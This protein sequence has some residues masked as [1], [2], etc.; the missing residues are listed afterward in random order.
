MKD[1]LDLFSGTE[2]FY[3]IGY[4]FGSLLTL[5]IAKLLESKGKK[6]VVTIIDGSPQFIHKLS[7]QVVPVN[8]D[9]NIQS[10]ILLTCARLLF[11]DEFHEIAKNIFA[12]KTWET[13]LKS[14]AEVAQERSLYSVEYGSKMLT[15]LITRLKISLAADKILLSTLTNTPVSLIRPAESSAKDL[16]EDY[17]LGKY[18]SNKVNV[19]VIDG[20]HASMLSN[21]ELIKLLNN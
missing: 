12:N 17:G 4:S 3:L 8:T 7:N 18:C 6:G 21:P 11:P 20:N 5:E 10:I 9:E 16:D 2:N 15:A 13:Q 19:T 1:I 14:F